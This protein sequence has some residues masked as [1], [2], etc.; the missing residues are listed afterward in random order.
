MGVIEFT[1]ALYFCEGDKVATLKPMLGFIQA[2]DNSRV[3]LIRKE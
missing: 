2:G 1:H 3:I